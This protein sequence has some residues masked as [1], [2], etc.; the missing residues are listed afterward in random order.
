MQWLY[1]VLADG[2]PLWSKIVSSVDKPFQHELCDHYDMF[3]ERTHEVSLGSMMRSSKKHKGPKANLLS[4]FT[5]PQRKRYDGH[6]TQLSGAS[7]V[8][9]MVCLVLCL[10][11]S[12]L[13]TKTEVYVSCLN[14]YSPT[15]WRPFV[16][17]SHLVNMQTSINASIS[18]ENTWQKHSLIAGHC[19]GIKLC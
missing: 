9:E 14:K 11:L 3:W 4:R 19:E 16:E 5:Q 7:A 10:I 13:N 8:T 1:S 2:T 18:I 6:H 12:D 15:F 17:G